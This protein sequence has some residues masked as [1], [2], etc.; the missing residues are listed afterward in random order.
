MRERAEDAAE[1]E[2]LLDTAFA[3]GRTALSSYR[4]RDG[5][6]P[7]A[8]LCLVARDEF[9][10]VVGAIRHWPVRI[11]P[12]GAPALLLGPVAVHPTRQGEGLGAILIGEAMERAA[13]LGWTRVLLVGD[14]PYYGRFGF[15]HALAAEV[16]FPPPTNPARILA[17]ELSS[18]AMT[19]VAG[20]VR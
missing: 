13:E 8:E 19:G 1:V 2:W 15:R 7:V 9:D 5:V 12:S 20:P 3:P 10:A 14:E 16:E 6:D 17:R 4:L 18:G 11:G